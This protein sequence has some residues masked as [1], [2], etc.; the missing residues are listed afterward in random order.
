M[1]ITYHGHSCFKLKGKRGSVVLDPYDDG[2][3]FG[4]PRLSAEIVTVS[5]DHFDHNAFGKIKGTPKKEN[6]FII[7]ESG[8]YEVGRISVFGTKTFHDDQKGEIRGRNIVYT[9][10]MD[11]LRVCHLGDLG[12]DLTADQLDEI[13]AIDILLCPVG[14]NY[15]IGPEQAAKTIR[16]LE[17]SIAIPMHYRTPEHNQKSFAELKTLEDFLKVFGVEPVPVPKLDVLNRSQLPSE[18]ELVVL[19]MT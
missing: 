8:E 2:V 11:D 13:G 4:M 17:P 3:G 16:A 14:G 10:L 6:P 12:H 15:T 19:R 7:E 1:I 5:H 18:T 9:V